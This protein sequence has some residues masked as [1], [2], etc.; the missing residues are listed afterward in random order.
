MRTT[1]VTA[2]LFRV[3]LH[4]CDATA[5]PARELGGALILRKGIYFFNEAFAHDSERDLV[6]RAI[7]YRR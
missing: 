5:R 2:M 3:P 7:D 4:M 6:G 1:I